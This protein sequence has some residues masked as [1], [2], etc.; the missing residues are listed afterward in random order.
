MIEEFLRTDNVILDLKSQTKDEVLEELVDKLVT[1]GYILDKKKVLSAVRAR[2]KLCS[3]GFEK[4]IAIPHPRQGTPTAVKELVAAIGISKNGIDF[5][6]LD[7]S[8]VNIFILL[9]AQNDQ[10]HLRALARLAR[11]L[12]NPEIRDRILAAVSKQGIVDII[13]EE[14][15][16]ILNG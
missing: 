11:I 7:K 1:S 15:H 12:K 14:E 8:P 16:N 5:A 6:A 2:E 10:Q 9:C 3:T 4:G 13:V